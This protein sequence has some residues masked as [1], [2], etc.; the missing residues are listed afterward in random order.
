MSV[1]RLHLQMRSAERRLRREGEIPWV[2]HLTNLAE[3]NIMRMETDTLTIR[4]AD[5][6]DQRVFHNSN[7]GI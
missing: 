5:F 4:H 1:T 2:S 3:L 7:D 6:H